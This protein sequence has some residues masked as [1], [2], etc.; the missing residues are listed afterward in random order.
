MKCSIRNIRCYFACKL[1]TY[2]S[3]G[4]QWGQWSS[5]YARFYLP[6]VLIWGLPSL[7]PSRQ[8]MSHQFVFGWVYLHKHKLIWII[9]QE[10][11]CTLKKWY[12][13]K[14]Y[15]NCFDEKK[16]EVN[17]HPWSWASICCWGGITAA[18]DIYFSVYGGPTKA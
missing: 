18:S 11:N 6:C 12:F 13:K 5:H 17:R 14:S 1:F 10:Y 2:F 4:L 9:V 8:K 7:E 15:L 16:V 3:F